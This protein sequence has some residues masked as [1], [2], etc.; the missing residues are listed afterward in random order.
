VALD[1]A[2]TQKLVEH[3]KRT[4]SVQVCPM[5]KQSHWQVHGQVMLSLGSTPGHPSPAGQSLPC[6]VVVC[7]ACGNS[8]IVNLIVAGIV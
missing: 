4:W 2:T 1:P 7:Q 5:C 6:A 3:L 8:V